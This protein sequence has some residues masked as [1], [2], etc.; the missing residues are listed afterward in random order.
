MTACGNC[1][2]GVRRPVVR[3]RTKGDMSTS[4]LWSQ[5][6]AEL[7][8]SVDNYGIVVT[9]RKGVLGWAEHLVKRGL[10][11]LILRHLDQ[12]REINQAVVR[13][14]EDLTTKFREEPA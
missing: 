3:A 9:R 7:K 4:H 6:L 11:K 13:A 2:Q 14:L 5:T 10:R 1:A 8:R 12:Q